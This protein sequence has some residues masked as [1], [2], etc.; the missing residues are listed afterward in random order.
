[1]Y[2]YFYIN[3]SRVHSLAILDLA[4][5]NPT[6]GDHRPWVSKCIFRS[7]LMVHIAAMQCLFLCQYCLCSFILTWSESNKC[8][9]WCVIYLHL[10]HSPLWYTVRVSI[11]IGACHKCSASGQVCGSPNIWT[12]G[13]HLNSQFHLRND[14]LIYNDSNNLSSCIVQ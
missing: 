11:H 10:D 14:C 3:T 8:W 12:T 4:Q 5:C 7:I 9:G 1:M 2:L 6:G 13:C